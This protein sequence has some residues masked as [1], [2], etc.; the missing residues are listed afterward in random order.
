MDELDP[1]AGAMP[2]KSFAQPC[3]GRRRG[4]P[5]GSRNKAGLAAEAVLEGAAEELMRALI[6]KALAGDGAALRFC[7]G[8]LLPVRRDRPVVFDLPPIESAGDLVKAGQAVLAA[9]AG[10]VLSPGEAKQVMDLV[11]SVRALVAIGERETRL[12][13]LEKRQ[14]ACAART[15]REQAAPC[16]R[17]ASPPAR[18][19]SRRR[20][21]LG[22]SGC[23]IAKGAPAPRRVPCKSP[24]FNSFSTAPAGRRTIREVS[25]VL[26]RRGDAAVTVASTRPI[27]GPPTH[28]A[29][30]NMSWRG[31]RGRGS[32]LAGARLVI[33]H[34]ALTIFPPCC[35]TRDRLIRPAGAARSGANPS[36][37]FL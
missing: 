3:G 21:T 31:A 9:C 23:E 10:G 22:A 33:G 8:R 25:P 26:L 13:A 34:L 11:T 7:V 1:A 12:I 32:R 14:Q 15:A 24:V 18:L 17:R 27:R 28:H 37:G 5:R 30:M 35:S 19:A 36:G 16:D 4:R 2:E 6:A 29:A 20:Q